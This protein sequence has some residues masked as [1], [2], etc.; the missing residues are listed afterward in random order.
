MT[1]ACEAQ[2]KFTQEQAELLAELAGYESG[3]DWAEDQGLCY[4][5]A[6]SCYMIEPSGWHER[7][8]GHLC[9]TCVQ[10]GAA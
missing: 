5:V 3:A 9:D 1:V 6:C 10:D 7:Y 2:A 8:N 4:C